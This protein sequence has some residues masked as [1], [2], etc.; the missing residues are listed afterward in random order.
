MV[1]NDNLAKRYN[2]EISSL[3]A[4]YFEYRKDKNHFPRELFDQFI[5]SFDIFSLIVREEDSVLSEEFM[6]FIRLISKEFAAF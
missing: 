1:Y 6:T 3:I 4:S 2:A 5:E